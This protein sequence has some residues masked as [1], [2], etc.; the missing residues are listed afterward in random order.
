MKLWMG[1]CRTTIVCTWWY[2]G[3]IRWF[4]LILAGI[5]C[6][7]W[8]HFQL[9]LLLTFLR[10]PS[11][12]PIFFSGSIY[13]WRS[14]E[15]ILGPKANVK[16]FRVDPYR[17]GN[18]IPR[19]FHNLSDLHE[20]CHREKFYTG[21]LSLNFFGSH[22]TYGE[23]RKKIGAKSQSKFF[24]GRPRQKKNQ[25]HEKNIIFRDRFSRRILLNDYDF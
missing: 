21:F 2:R 16:F 22:Y 5:G 4:L 18:R 8:C 14:Q 17:L 23:V 11:I 10:W 12:C 24:Q 6:W 15:K 19:A 1:Q 3:S 25:K 13:M 9:I 20:W 7:N